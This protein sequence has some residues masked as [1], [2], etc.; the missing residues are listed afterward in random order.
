[1][2][3]SKSL[4]RRRLRLSQARFRSTTQRP[5]KANCVGHAFAISTLH[6]PNFFSGRFHK[7]VAGVV[8]IGEEVAQPWEEVVNGLDDEWRAIAVLHIGGVDR[9]ADHQADAIG[10]DMSLAAPG[11]RRGR[12]LIFLAAW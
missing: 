12:L 10:H 6:L 11:L 2:E 4:A 3:A 5:R 1:M 9:G 7:L 8:A